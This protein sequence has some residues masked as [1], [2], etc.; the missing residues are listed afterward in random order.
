VGKMYGSLRI[1]P[2][3]SLHVSILTLK[4]DKNTPVL[5][6]Y[7][8]IH[9]E[10]MEIFISVHV[11]GRYR[12][13]VKCEREKFMQKIAEGQREK[14]S[15]TNKEEI[16]IFLDHFY[17]FVKQYLEDILQNCNDK[18]PSRCEQLVRDILSQLQ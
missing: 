2:N 9:F 5:I 10:G 1:Y 15:I 3:F 14:I 13:I 8:V 12:V 4:S 11:D 18:L 17:I 16:N 6:D 7:M